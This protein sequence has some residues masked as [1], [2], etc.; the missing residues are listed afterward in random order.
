M[1]NAAP[2]GQLPMQKPLSEWV[3]VLS[4]QS[5]PVMKSTIQEMARVL[6]TDNLPVKAMVDTV[7]RDPGLA[8]HLIRTC[9]NRS[10]GHLSTE[11]TSVQQAVMMLGMQKLALLP[12]T[13]PALE[14]STNKRSQFHLLRIFSTAYHAA[15]QATEWARQRRDMIPDEIFIAAQLHFIGEMLLA[16]DAPELLD[17][18]YQ[19]R[20]EEHV[21][22]EEAHYLILG[23]TIDQLSLAIARK[24][25]LPTLLIESLQAE[26]AHLP[27]AYGI[28]LA[29]QVARSASY[30]W[31]WD[32]ML[33]MQKKAADWLGKSS[34]TVI[35]ETHQLAVKVARASTYPSIMAAAFKL[36]HPAP[37]ASEDT[38]DESKNKNSHVGV[39]LVPQIA[40]LKHAL[41]GL[42]ALPDHT[43]DLH[44]VTELL[45]HGLHNGAGLN[46]A[47]F[48][49][50]DPERNTLKAR[51]VVG[52]DNDPFFS[53][54]EMPLNRPNLFEKMLEKQQ[55]LW[56][57][58]ENRKRYWEIIPLEFRRLIKTNSFLVMS[59]V[60]HERTVGIVYADR[61]TEDCHLDETA[62]KYFK[63]MCL[64]TTEA[65]KRMKRMR[66]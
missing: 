43:N 2:P 62:Y 61:H 38:K 40:Q 25:E 53:R 19:L 24:L 18:I 15:V 31:Y 63:A 26:S 29:V 50:H 54:M 56:L 21:P 34:Q 27:R 4:A 16:M 23:F 49:Y 60:N 17:R 22:T 57:N 32:K 20:N 36:L 14:V 1:A 3:D 35:R 58:D 46:R 11:V 59:I 42:K 41:G 6:K 9:S 45:L 47:A 12:K 39:C 33:E 44:K 55:A 10:H 48:V 30:S 5:I 66:Y 28:M 51:G 8:L 52:V 13:L 37:I 65:L 7:E 64:Q